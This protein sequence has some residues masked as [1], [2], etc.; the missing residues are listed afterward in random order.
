MN[1]IHSELRKLDLNLLLVFEALFRQ[2]SV[3]QASNELC[4]SAS[5]V[6]HALA[7]L[8]RWQTFG[9]LFYF[10]SLGVKNPM[11][12][13]GGSGGMVSSRTASKI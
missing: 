11:D 4:M 6:S 13:F 9:L 3:T 7:R 5:A 2:G 12:R 1:T 10:L 8:R